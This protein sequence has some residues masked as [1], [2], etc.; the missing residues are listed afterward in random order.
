LAA[1][2]TVAQSLAWNS[3]RTTK[4]NQ[5][6]QGFT[7]IEV[8]AALSIITVLMA[9]V[10][11]LIVFAAFMVAQSK[12]YNQ[13]MNWIQAD[14]ESVQFRAR[15]YEKQA[16]P[17]SSR[18]LATIAADGLA[19]GFISDQLGGASTTFGPRFIGG[20][21]LMLNRTAVYSTS[22]DPFKLLQLTYTVTPQSGGAP[23]ASLT[24]EVV[25]YAAFK[26]P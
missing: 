10:M 9:T 17:F 6:I 4:K 3:L 25:P 24:T 2:Q 11:Q 15:E 8:L 12:Q 26:C 7:L 5:R 19:A 20:K 14:A 1:S 18:C 23:I 16:S 13:A 22:A 21:N